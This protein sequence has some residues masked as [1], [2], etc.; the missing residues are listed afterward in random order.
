[1]VPD[2]RSQLLDEELRNRDRNSAL[3]ALEREIGRYPAY[4]GLTPDEALSRSKTAASN[5][6]KLLEQLAGYGWGPVQMYHRPT[7]QN[8]DQWRQRSRAHRRSPR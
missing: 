3:L 5:E 2:L 1:L 4:L 7:R 8:P 6:K